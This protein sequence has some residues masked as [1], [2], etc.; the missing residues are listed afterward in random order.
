MRYS[1]PNKNT[2]PNNKTKPP[3]HLSPAQT[4]KE[5][6]YGIIHKERP[7][8][9]SRPH[10]TSNSQ[11]A[12]GFGMCVCAP[13]PGTQGKV[14]R[15]RCGASVTRTPISILCSTCPHS[16]H[17]HST[18]HLP[19]PKCSVGLL[20]VPHSPTNGGIVAAYPQARRGGLLLFS[21]HSR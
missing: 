1:S 4:Q 18:P 11:C 17:P 10:C 3:R 5:K 8:P 6:A 21:I 2:T 14:L 19:I 7:R 15:N 9:A 13:A 20:T 16:T 12:W